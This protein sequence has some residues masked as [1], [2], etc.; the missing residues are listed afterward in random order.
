MFSGF[1][2]R[3]TTPCRGCIQA[4]QHLDGDANGA[5]LRHAA[6]GEDVA[7]QPAF[8][9]LHHHV[10]ARAFLAAVDAHHHGVIQLFADGGF[11]LEAIEEDGVGFHVGVRNLQARRRGCRAHPQR[12]RST[13][14]RCA[15]L[16]LQCGRNRFANRLLWCRECPL[17]GVSSACASST[18]SRFSGDVSKEFIRLWLGP[19]QEGSR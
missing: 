1:R 12:E 16:G 18:L 3:W 15:L 4:L 5:I 2:S 19:I 14:C 6:F 9:P 7:Q 17:G 10:D 11:A 8:A 13:P